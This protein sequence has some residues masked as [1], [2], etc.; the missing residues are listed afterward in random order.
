MIMNKLSH[1]MSHL[2]LWESKMRMIPAW[3][4]FQALRLMVSVKTLESTNDIPMNNNQNLEQQG[5]TQD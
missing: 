4:D 5:R 2:V 1:P 3:E